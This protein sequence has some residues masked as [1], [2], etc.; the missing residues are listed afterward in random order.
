MI[1]DFGFSNFDFDPPEPFNHEGTEA[2]R[3][4]TT[5]LGTQRFRPAETPRIL[6]QPKSF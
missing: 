2:P 3:F 5:N 4:R 1:F 6:A